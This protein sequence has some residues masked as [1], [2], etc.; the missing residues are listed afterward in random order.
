MQVYTHAPLHRCT[1]RLRRAFK[2]TLMFQAGLATAAAAIN[3][4]PK[5]AFPFK[6]PFKDFHFCLLKEKKG[7]ALMASF[8]LLLLLLIQTAWFA[9]YFFLEKVRSVPPTELSVGS[10]IRELK[11]PFSIR[12]QGKGS[13]HGVFFTTCLIN[14]WPSAASDWFLSSPRR[15]GKSLWEIPSQKSLTFIKV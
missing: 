15:A 6:G 7:E 1:L 4:A 2:R 9:H 12:A 8:F 5:L 11:P 13:G 10:L 3:A 14:A